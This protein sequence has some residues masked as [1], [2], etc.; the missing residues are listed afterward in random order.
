MLFQFQKGIVLSVL[1]ST[2]GTVTSLRVLL[3][4]CECQDHFYVLRD[5]ERYCETKK[6]VVITLG[7][8]S[9]IV[10]LLKSP[11]RTLSER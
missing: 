3:V 10:Q 8:E 5:L 2:V 4:F 11:L 1:V 7:P 6:L 9:D